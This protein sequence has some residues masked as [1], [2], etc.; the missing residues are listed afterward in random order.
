M[1]ELPKSRHASQMPTVDC[2]QCEAPQSLPSP[3]ISFVWDVIVWPP[4]Q[5]R[6]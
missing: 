6:N 2:F 5:S 4:L 1:V 3:R